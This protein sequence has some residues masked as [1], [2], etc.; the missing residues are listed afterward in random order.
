[1]P[2]LNRRVKRFLLP[3]ANG[4]DEISEMVLLVLTASGRTR[5]LIV[6][7]PGPV[8][9]VAVHRHEA[10]RAVENV[11][12]GVV[13]S[14]VRPELGLA[15]LRFGCRESGRR[16]TP[17]ESALANAGF[18]VGDPAP[19]FEFQHL[20]FAV[21]HVEFAGNVQGVRR[22]LVVVKHEVAA[23]RGNFVGI[24]DAQSPARD[25]HFMDALVAD[26]AVAVRP[27]PMPV[28]MEPVF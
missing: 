1:M 23:H 27:V 12:D 21:R 7:E 3:A 10:F 13:V 14:G 6:A 8:S 24:A 22:L 9:V 20:A 11:P 4:L 16:N 18:V 26:V 2:F 5:L 15:G 17:L 28:V 25:I 19:D